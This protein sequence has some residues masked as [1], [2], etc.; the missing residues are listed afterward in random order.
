M[1]LHVI[2]VKLFFELNR[3]SI[4]AL[5]L[6]FLTISLNYILVSI[7]EN[8]NIGK[9]LDWDL[10]GV[11]PRSVF[12]LNA[13][14]LLI[15]ICSLIITVEYMGSMFTDKSDI[16]S[17]CFKNLRSR[18]NTAKPEPLVKEINKDADKGKSDEN[19]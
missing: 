6:L 8:K 10:V 1:V 13:F 19:L 9:L 4:F 2:F 11:G 17:L 15:G 12:N 14:L 3:V 18:V 16:L 7:F 5:N